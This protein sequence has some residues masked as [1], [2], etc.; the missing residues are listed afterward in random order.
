MACG[1]GNR[2]GMRNTGFSGKRDSLPRTVAPPLQA[3]A[4]F[5]APRETPNQNGMNS[6]RRLVEKRRRDA[7]K[8]LGKK[9]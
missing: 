2:G 7:I 3:Q 5:L 1:C 4:Q 8:K 6:S 9:A